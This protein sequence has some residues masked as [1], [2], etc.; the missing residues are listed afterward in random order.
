MKMLRRI[1]AVMLIS[2]TIISNVSA[3]VAYDVK[4][5]EPAKVD[6]VLFDKEKAEK[7]KNQLL[8]GDNSKA[9]AE[10]LK[11]ILKIEQDNSTLKDKQIEILKD[12]NLDLAKTHSVTGVEKTLYFIGGMGAVLL[13]AIAISKVK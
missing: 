2:S 10:S 9:Q 11:K 6:G 3:D 12:T 8:D 7:I 13:G 4:I 5:G 1:L